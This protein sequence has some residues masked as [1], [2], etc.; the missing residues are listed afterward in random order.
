MG[1]AAATYTNKTTQ[2][3]EKTRILPAGYRAGRVTIIDSA[4]DVI[5]TQAAEDLRILPADYRAGRVTIIDDSA[6]NLSAQAAEALRLIPAR[7]RAGR[8]TII[9]STRVTSA[10]AAEKPRIFSTGY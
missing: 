8:V 2:T 3:A 1:D 9:D 7:Y 5:P 6:R 4:M 10:Q